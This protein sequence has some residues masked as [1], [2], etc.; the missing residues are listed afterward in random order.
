M[1]VSLRLFT[2]FQKYL[3]DGKQGRVTLRC[4]EDERIGELLNRLGLPQD[5]PKI[6]LVN[7]TQKTL[8]DVLHDGDMLDVFPPIAGG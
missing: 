7:G 1:N 5:V 2:V 4:R 8:D 3:P 6:I